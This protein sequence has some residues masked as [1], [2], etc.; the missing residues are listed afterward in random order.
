MPAVRLN[1][2]DPFIV[3][4]TSATPTSSDIFSVTDEQRGVLWR[5]R[6]PMGWG[7][8]AAVGW[9]CLRWGQAVCSL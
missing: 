4:T 3:N 7:C 6:H 5:V 9:S 1:S 8:Q 2:A